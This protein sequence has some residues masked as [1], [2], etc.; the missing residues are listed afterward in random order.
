MNRVTVNADEF[1]LPPWSDSLRVYALRVLD[2]ISR[3][4][5]D[6]SVLLCTDKTIKSLNSR[7]RNIDEA[8]DVLSFE[9]GAEETMPDG[10]IRCYPGDIVISLDSV[11][12][13]AHY[14][15]VSADEELRRLLIHGIL[16][17]NGMDHLSN[18]ASEPMLLKQENILYTL[19]EEHI[20]SSDDLLHGGR[21]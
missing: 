11:G 3:D 21:T 7:Y 1:S 12:K 10:S 5:W 19:K 2:S 17:L 4:N 14:F 13:N 6:L 9:L 16:H 20:L 15:R 18:D 8:T